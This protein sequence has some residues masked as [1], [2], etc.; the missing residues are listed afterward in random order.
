[1]KKVEEADKAAEEV[2]KAS[3]KMVVEESKEDP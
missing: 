2:T 1:M 3:E